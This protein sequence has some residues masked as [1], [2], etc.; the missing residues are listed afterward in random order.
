MFQQSMAGFSAWDLSER[1]QEEEGAGNKE[2]E[3]N[4]VRVE[5]NQ[6]ATSR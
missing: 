5:S 3:E 2:S 1:D 6:Q 4:V